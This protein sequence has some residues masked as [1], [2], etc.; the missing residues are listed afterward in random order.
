MPY[1]DFNIILG[2]DCFMVVEFFTVNGQVVSFVV[3][4][5]WVRSDGTKFTVARYDTAHG[6][7]H[8]D[9]V[10]KAGRLLSKRW[11]FDMGFK[12]ALSYSIQDFRQHHETYIKA[13]RARH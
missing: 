8:L 4:L 10:N 7:A 2:D 12:D 11:L 6:R 13:F 5:V 3:R 9:T 1:E